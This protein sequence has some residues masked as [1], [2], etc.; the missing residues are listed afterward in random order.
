M[1]WLRD[2]LARADDQPPDFKAGCRVIWDG[3]NTGGWLFASE[4]R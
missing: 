1:R 4:L 2:W 3:D